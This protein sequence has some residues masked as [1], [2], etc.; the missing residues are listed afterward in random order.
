MAL[1]QISPAVALLRSYRL[2]SLWADLLAGLTLGAYLIPAGL[3]DASLANLP[4]EAGLYAC[5]FS[6]LVFWFFCSSRHT[7]VTVTS[8]ISLLV[9]AS[10]GEIAGGDTTRFA[11]LA[12]CTAIMAGVLA[13]LTWLLNAGVVINFVSETV[14]VGFKCGIALVLASTQLPKLFGMS[15]SHGDFWERAWHFISHL[16]QTNPWALLVGGAALLV[17]ALGKVLLKNVPVAL[18]VV[19]A[20]IIV[21]SSTG[22]ASHGVKMLGEVPR[23]IPTPRLPDVRAS[24]L[25]ALLP[26]AMACFLLGA[27]E[28]AAIGRMFARK[29]GYRFEPNQEFLA[30]GAANLGAG[31][32]LG[33]PVS[34][35]MSQSLVNESGGARTPISGLVASLLM[36]VVLIA[37]SHLLKDLPQPVLAAIV[38]MAVT[39]L[40]KINVLKHLWNFSRVEFAVSMAA[41]LGVLGSGILRGVLIGAVLSLL[42]LLRRSS[43]PNTTE[44]GRVPGTSF[45][46]SLQRHPEN[47]VESRALIFRTEGSILYF[48]ADY[49]CD[50]LMELLQRRT[51]KVQLVIFFMGMVPTVDLA[52][53]E[54]LMD[55]H[56]TLRAQGIDFQLAEA[57]GEVREALRRVGYVESCGKVEANQTV[58]NLLSAW[59]ER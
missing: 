12:A 19:V 2:S 39:G 55:L 56:K 7:A 23:G 3:G 59:R 28:T 9:G 31:L 4:A 52:G 32:G 34:G 29:H 49:V 50:R 40:I 20:G 58:D 22:L 41:M 5:L 45:F 8:A 35:G 44:L 11:S 27:V 46:A 10:I 54:L 36:V 43:R 24:D 48:N 38:L 1:L 15:G 37:L 18:F 53:A 25:N 57:R 21:A 30:L 6:G 26:L 42:M 16:P 13:V 14:L 47:Q 17:L 51:D 33:F